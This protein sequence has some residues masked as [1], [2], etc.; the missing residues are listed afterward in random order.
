MH[1][2]VLNSSHTLIDMRAKSTRHWR[3]DA[4][5]ALI[6]LADVQLRGHAWMENEDVW[7]R[8][9]GG[10]QQNLHVT[11]PGCTCGL[12]HLYYTPCKCRAAAWF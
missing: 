3:L 10:L 6:V 9:A 2:A 7:E 12:S 5:L 8:P 11:A 4:C 1:Q